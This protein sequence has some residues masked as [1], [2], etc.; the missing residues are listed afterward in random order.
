[1]RRLS[2]RPR[3]C[4]TA[5]SPMPWRRSHRM[6]N[7]QRVAAHSAAQLI[8]GIYWICQ[9]FINGWPLWFDQ[10]WRDIPAGSNAY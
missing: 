10:P 1:M 2:W 4:S 5:D 6:R 3:S 9:S 8:S 7:R